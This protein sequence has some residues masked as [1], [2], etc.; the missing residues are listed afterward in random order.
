MSSRT[1]P[2]L[3]PFRL[4]AA[5]V[6][7]THRWVRVEGRESRVDFKAMQV[8]LVLAASTGETVTKERLLEDV[9]EGRFVG[10]DVLT[11][12]V[13]QLRKALGDNARAPRFIETVPRVG[14]RLL[15]AAEPAAALL[16]GRDGR[17][18]WRL[19]AALGVLAGVTALA[20]GAALPVLQGADSR[21]APAVWV[22]TFEA[23]P[24][25]AAVE[26]A[27][28]E[29]RAALLVL[30]ARDPRTRVFDGGQGSVPEADAERFRVSG[31]VRRQEVSL[32]VALQ[33]ADS[34]S[35]EVLWAVELQGDEPAIEGLRQR[36]VQAFRSG[37]IPRIADHPR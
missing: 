16:T 14:Y 34:G 20:L 12:A 19:L 7:P 10:E 1:L 27:A 23:V 4:G 18:R 5:L 13:S 30:L 33:V 22:D 6:H 31:R 8:L 15:M 26:Q 37:A 2:D 17:F 3:R 29:L 11:V 35:G 28:T 25:D 21:T 36:V 9:W 32:R 24:G